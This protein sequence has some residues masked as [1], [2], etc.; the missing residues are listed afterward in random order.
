M[1]RMLLWLLT[2]LCTED[3][4]WCVAPGWLVALRND[5]LA[6]ILQPSLALLP[7]PVL[8][9]GI[10]YAEQTVPSG[11]DAASVLA[12]FDQQASIAPLTADHDVVYYIV[13]TANRQ[14]S[15]RCGTVH[16]QRG[17]ALALR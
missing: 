2:W 10:G 5:Y 1:L 13:A 14:K 9:A 4:P 15:W 12:F 3:W 7:G 17:P 6:W 11:T 8:A 16:A